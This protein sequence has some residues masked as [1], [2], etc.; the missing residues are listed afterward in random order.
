ML[1]KKQQRGNKSEES[2]SPRKK[3]SGSLS[4]A[5]ARPAGKSQ[6]GRVATDRKQAIIDPSVY[7]AMALRPTGAT[8]SFLKH[9]SPGDEFDVLWS[10]KLSYELHEDLNINKKFA[11]VVPDDL[12]RR[13][14]DDLEHFAYLVD[15]V[16]LD[17][18]L[19]LAH[20]R[21]DDY[22]VALACKHH[23]VLV[24]YD[25]RLRKNAPH[26]VKIMRPAEFM[27][28]ISGGTVV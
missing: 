13:L 10:Q 11:D 1:S 8:A 6:S 27:A 9:W 22:L 16:K 25:E 12:K 23:V 28:Y 19:P 3:Q 7:V 5:L 18:P 15:D 26:G 2:R 4:K 24:T 17:N 21:D 20:D 14:F